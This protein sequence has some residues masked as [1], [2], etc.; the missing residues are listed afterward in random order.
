[1][2][3]EHTQ[4]TG[5]H[6]GTVCDWKGRH[7][8]GRLMVLIHPRKWS[9]AVDDEYP[10]LRSKTKSLK[11]GTKPC[12]T[13]VLPAAYLLPRVIT[14]E[15]EICL[16]QL[17][18]WN[19]THTHTHTQTSDLSCHIFPSYRLNSHFYN[20]LFP[21]ICLNH[22]LC[23]RLDVAVSIVT[24]HLALWLFIVSSML[25]LLFTACHYLQWQTELHRHRPI[26]ILPKKC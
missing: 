23:V 22:C 2:L 1:M 3:N 21:S 8:I 12:R 6:K 9:R 15:K 5:T 25:H 7:D 26:S 24:H 19:K 17:F 16:S 10:T 18:W 20:P 13:V 4:L 14:V 11:K